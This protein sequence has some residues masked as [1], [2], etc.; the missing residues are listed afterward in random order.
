MPGSSF[1]DSL[2]V[3]RNKANSY[4]L[5][6]GGQ[7]LVNVIEDFPVYTRAGAGINSQRA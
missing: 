7:R 5:A 4:R 3:I 2:D 1:G 6:D